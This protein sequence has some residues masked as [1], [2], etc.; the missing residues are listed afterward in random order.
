LRERNLSGA[1]SQH[2]CQRGHNDYFFHASL[3]DGD[4]ALVKVMPWGAVP[5][6]LGR[7]ATTF[8]QTIIAPSRNFW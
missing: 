5:K 8:A 6:S 7:A 2:E 1:N 3:L 4:F